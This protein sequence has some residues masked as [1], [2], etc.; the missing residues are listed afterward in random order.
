M[1]DTD[2][3]HCMRQKGFGNEWSVCGEGHWWCELLVF[4]PKEA[5]R[6]VMNGTWD[7][8]R[9]NPVFKAFFDVPEV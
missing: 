3:I 9:E 5:G 6:S 7:S 1:Y 2:F 4:L 8:G